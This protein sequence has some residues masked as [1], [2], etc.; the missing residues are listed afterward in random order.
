MLCELLTTSGHEITEIN[1]GHQG[2]AEII[3]NR[4]DV[5]ILDVSMP[6]FSGFDVLDKLDNDGK[7]SENSI[8]LFTAIPISDDEIKKWTNKG[9][10]DCLKKPIRIEVIINL[11]KEIELKQK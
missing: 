7:L 1:D 10:V 9:L 2:Y 11:M 3:Q 6:E 5:V 4:Y 8:V